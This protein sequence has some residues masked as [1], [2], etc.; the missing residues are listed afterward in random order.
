ME[1]GEWGALLR[2]QPLLKP[3][4]PSESEDSHSTHAAAGLNE[5]RY[6]EGTFLLT[7]PALPQLYGGWN[8][9]SPHH[10]PTPHYQKDAW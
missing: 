3:E 5:H 8:T 1:K 7:Q 4:Q 9:G 2:L 6:G 10:H